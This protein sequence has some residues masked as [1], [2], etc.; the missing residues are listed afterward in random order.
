MVENILIESYVAYIPFEFISEQHLR[1]INDYYSIHRNAFFRANISFNEKLFLVTKYGSRLNYQVIFES[2][3]FSQFLDREVGRLTQL[4]V[5]GLI[6]QIVYAKAVNKLHGY[7]CKLKYVPSND[8][9]FEIYDA[10]D[11]KRRPKHGNPQEGVTRKSGPGSG[12][13]EFDKKHQFEDIVFGP[14]LTSLIRPFEFD[15]ASESVNDETE[16]NIAILDSGTRLQRNITEAWNSFHSD[17]FDTSS[18]NCDDVLG[19]GTVIHQILQEG[20]L[21]QYQFIPVKVISDQGFVSI[22]DVMAG[23]MFVKNINEQY[24]F[25]IFCKEFSNY[26]NE[27]QLNCSL[28]YLLFPDDEVAKFRNEHKNFI[29]E[30]KEK[31]KVQFM[32]ISLG[33]PHK[34]DLLHVILSKMGNMKIVCSAGNNR[35]N[36]E[37]TFHS[38]SMYSRI[39]TTIYIN[40]E[41]KVVNTLDNLYEAIGGSSVKG[42]NVNL[43]S[44]TNYINDPHQDYPN[45]IVSKAKYG[46]AEGTSISCANLLVN[47]IQ[48]NGSPQASQKD[49]N[50]EL[51]TDKKTQSIL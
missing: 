48:N 11:G 18:K 46:S 21:N 38:P 44:A 9:L 42:K 43:W 10:Y 16:T 51:M 32:N 37:E 33:F 14:N 24:Q 22:L 36:L 7:H 41:Q 19:H 40:E 29:R 45:S 31:L 15:L 23:L 2:I 8:L 39:E 34:S 47:L 4:L 26:F 28:K 35:N 49:W 27:R 12:S 13:D 6:T 50:L 1:D 30:I 5:D 25:S 17:P 3:V 20:L